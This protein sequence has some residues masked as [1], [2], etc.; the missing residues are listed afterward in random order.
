[1]NINVHIHATIHESKCS[2]T[3]NNRAVKD[4][5]KYRLC[6]S[7]IEGKCQLLVDDV[8]VV[9]LLLLVLVACSTS[10]TVSTVPTITSK[11]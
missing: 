7:V 8:P 2:H 11:G 3:C 5:A 9:L 6:V 4:C 1:M 10:L